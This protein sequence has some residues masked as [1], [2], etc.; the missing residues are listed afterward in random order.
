MYS[1]IPVPQTRSGP[2]LEFE[3]QGCLRY[4]EYQLRPIGLGSYLNLTHQ[5]DSFLDI[6][7][8]DRDF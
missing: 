6:N 5:N 2:E 3:V 4:R 8:M 7:D 1:G